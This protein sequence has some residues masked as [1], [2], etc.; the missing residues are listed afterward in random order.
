[1]FRA[2]LF[3][4]EA[5]QFRSAGIRLGSDLFDVERKLMEEV[6]SPFPLEI[7]NQAIRMT[8]L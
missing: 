7:R 4:S 8:R 3:E 1:M 6:L 5:D 2:L